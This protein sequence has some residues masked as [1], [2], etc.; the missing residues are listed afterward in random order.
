MA[1]TN[2]IKR[3]NP[4]G[5]EFKY[6]GPEPEW[7]IQPTSENRI[8]ALG[9]AFAWYNYHYGKKDAKEMI[10]VYLDRHDRPKDAKKIR[11]TPDSQ[12]RMTTGWLCRM[13]D[14]GLQLDEHEQIKLDNMITEIL[15]VKEQAKIEVAEEPDVAKP[16][17][18]D[19]KSTQFNSG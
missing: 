17:I 9:K 15:A 13:A 4:K 7:R 18:Q 19:Q 1:K 10:A 3:L 5:A 12:I 6:V 2:E 8:S 14:M 11:S 16:N